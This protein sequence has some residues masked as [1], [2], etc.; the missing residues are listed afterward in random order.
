MRAIDLVLGPRVKDGSK[1]RSQFWA[2]T[3]CYLLYLLFSGGNDWRSVE[4]V[5]FSFYSALQLCPVA[6]AFGASRSWFRFGE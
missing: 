1:F 6:P 4:G 5:Y 2:C 3:N